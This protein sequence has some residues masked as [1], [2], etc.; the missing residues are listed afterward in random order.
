MT[1]RGLGG[2][3]PGNRRMKLD[4]TPDHAS[5]ILGA[6]ETEIAQQRAQQTRVRYLGTAWR[7]RLYLID[8]C[9]EI[10]EEIRKASNDD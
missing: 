8:T 3:I 9:Q 1:A 7:G 4:L 2:R 5:V 10:A 6:L